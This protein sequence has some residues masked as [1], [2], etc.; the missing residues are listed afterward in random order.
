[1]ALEEEKDL[2]YAIRALE[3]LMSSGIG[4][5][6]AI[7]SLSE[8]G[9][10]KISKDFKGVLD[11]GRKGQSMD[12][13]LRKVMR[14]TKSEAYKRL[15]NALVNNIVS[16]TDI[17]DTLRTQ[18]EREEESRNEKVEKY[19]ENLSGLPEG[20]L[21]VG[22]IFPIILSLYAIAPSLGDLSAVGVNFP[23]PATIQ[24]HVMVGLA[25]T[26]LIMFAIGYKAHS[27]DPGL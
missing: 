20:L 10:G 1:M 4:L 17:I 26:L 27:K 22:M 23:P 14:G 3:L 12:Q 24:F 21:S 15:L 19:I 6:A 11:A 18:G 8:G 5:E 2:L 9:Y 7:H 16:N 25:V 13:E